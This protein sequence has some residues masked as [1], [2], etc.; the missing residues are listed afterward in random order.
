MAMPYQSHVLAQ[1]PDGEPGIHRLRKFGANAH[2]QAGPQPGF[3]LNDPG[4]PRS[5]AG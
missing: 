2:D 1:I 4:R 3:M 5:S